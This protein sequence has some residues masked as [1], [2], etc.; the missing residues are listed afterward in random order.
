MTFS[1]IDPKNSPF[2]LK[3]KSNQILVVNGS[4]NFEEKSVYYL[5]IRVTDTVGRHLQTPFI[6]NIKGESLN[7]G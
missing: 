7:I 4:L 2:T 3:G 1:L 6:I 5:T